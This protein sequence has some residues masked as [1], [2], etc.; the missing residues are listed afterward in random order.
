MERDPGHAAR[1]RA[2][3]LGASAACR[4]SFHG[5][6]HC[7]ERARAVE[8]AQ[9]AMALC[10]DATM[11]AVLG[12]ALTLL[13]ELDVAAQRD[14]AR[15][16]SVDGGSAWA[17]GRSGWIDVYRGRSGI[18]HRAF[19]DRARPRAARSAG[20]QQHGRHRLRAFL[21]RSIMPKAAALAGD[22]AERSIHP[23]SGCIE[24]CAPAY[25]L[26]RRVAAGAPQPGHAPGALSRTNGLGSSSLACRRCG[27][28]TVISLSGRSRKPGCPPSSR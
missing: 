13:G 2:G 15:R 22:G 5:R 4:L 3:R 26:C 16:L 7:Q 27:R 21:R 6:S 23:R 17:W 9:R 14:H 25:V 1:H 18:G 12:N 28:R 8:L 24:R 10:G 11:L 20:V 19:Q